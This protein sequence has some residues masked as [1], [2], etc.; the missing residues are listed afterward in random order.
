MS[1]MMLMIGLETRRRSI[2][3]DDVCT[4]AGRSK[5]RHCKFNCVNHVQYVI[6]MVSGFGELSD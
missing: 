3:G 2:S 5:S 4:V 1:M 6:T